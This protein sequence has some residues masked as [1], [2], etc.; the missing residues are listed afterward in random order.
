MWPPANRYIILF[1]YPVIVISKG[2]R[3]LV[4]YPNTVSGYAFG[5]MRKGQTGSFEGFT[6][7]YQAEEE[8][9]MA[10]G[11]GR[12]RCFAS[13]KHDLGN[14]VGSQALS[15]F[16]LIHDIFNPPDLTIQMHRIIGTWDFFPNPCHL[17]LSAFIEDNGVVTV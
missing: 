16:P 7:K 3:M 4:S 12:I 15:S 9:V 17:V 14:H 10:E 8:D 13:C 5:A 6:G 11:Q 1:V 2:T